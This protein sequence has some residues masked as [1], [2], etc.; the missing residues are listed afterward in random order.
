VLEVANDIV[1][2][3]EPEHAEA[4][5]SLEAWKDWALCSDAKVEG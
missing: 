4:W 1:F 3:R 5:C 2:F